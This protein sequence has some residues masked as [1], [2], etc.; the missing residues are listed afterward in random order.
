MEEKENILGYENVMRKFFWL[1]FPEFSTLL[2][3]NELIGSAYSVLL[4]AMKKRGTRRR[5]G[6]LKKI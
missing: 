1:N 5:N 4:L 2:E 3:K 6:I